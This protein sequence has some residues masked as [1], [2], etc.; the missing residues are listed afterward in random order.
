M[1]PFGLVLRDWGQTKAGLTTPSNL[2]D[3]PR[4]VLGHPPTFLFRPY[5]HAHCR[6]VVEFGRQSCYESS[7]AR[8]ARGGELN[9]QLGADG[10]EQR[11]KESC[12]CSNGG[13]TFQTAVDFRTTVDLGTAFGTTLKRSLDF[14]NRS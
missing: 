1:A 9:E 6:P 5:D 10:S 11:R 4:R 2:V 3:Q 12:D 14:Q 7:A 8:E 13:V